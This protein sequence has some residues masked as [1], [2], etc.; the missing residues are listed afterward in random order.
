MWL[1]GGGIKAGRMFGLTDDLGFNVAESPMHVHD[2]LATI[3]HLP[4]FN[5]E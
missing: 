3:L 1:S 4:G 5:H 2:L